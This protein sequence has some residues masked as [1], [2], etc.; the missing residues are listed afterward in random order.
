MLVVAFNYTT[1]AVNFGNSGAFKM[2]SSVVR[3]WTIGSVLRYQSGEVLRA[4]ATP[5]TIHAAAARKRA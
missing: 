2:L 4:P 5:A 1:P 3:D